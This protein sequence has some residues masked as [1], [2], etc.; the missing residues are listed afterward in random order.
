MTDKPKSEVKFEDTPAIRANLASRALTQLK[1][2]NLARYE[3]IAKDLFAQ[4]GLTYVRRLTPLERKQQ[5]FERLATELGVDI[6]QVTP[7]A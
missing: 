7:S 3:E 4:H 1:Q 2:E 6:S 5:E